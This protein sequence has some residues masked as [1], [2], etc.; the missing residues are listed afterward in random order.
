M[1]K[2]FEGDAVKLNHFMAGRAN[3]LKL[4]MIAT[5]IGGGGVIILPMLLPF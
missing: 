3:R 2:E 4:I 1:A 5:G